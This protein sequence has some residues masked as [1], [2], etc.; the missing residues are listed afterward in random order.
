MIIRADLHVHS[1]YSDGRASPAEIIYASIERG[2]NAVAIT[3]HDTFAGS[4]AAKNLS[5]GNAI[6][7]VPGVEVRTDRGDVL[8]YC[9]N[10][11][12]FPKRLDLLIDRATREGCLLVPAHPF[13]LTR[14]GIGDAIFEYKEWA[15]I[16]VWNSSSTKGANRKAINATRLLNKP[17]IANSDAHVIGEIASAYNVIEVEELTVESLL[18]A[19]RGNRVRPV[20]GGRPFSSVFNR[21]SWSIERS[22]RKAFK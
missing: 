2:I 14:F 20:F 19:I 17:G 3:D 18:S 10:E 4:T 7:V 12:D 16:E 15:A 22:I 9:E 21:I 8:L 13:D 1:T 11:I 6:L 5:A